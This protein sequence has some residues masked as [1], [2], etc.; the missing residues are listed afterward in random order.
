MN[1]KSLA[2]FAMVLVL[3]FFACD[4][5]SSASSED[6]GT[7]SSSSSAT[8]SS[9]ASKISSSSSSKI[10]SSSSLEKR[11]Y[12]CQKYKCI[13]T[14]Y[15]NQDLL[16][17]GKY[18]ELL[19]ERDQ[20]V[21]RTIKIG[22]Q[23]WMAQGLNLADPA[24]KS[25]CESSAMDDCN[26]KGRLYTWGAAMDSVN[27]GCGYGSKCSPTLP[28]Q[29]ICPKGWHLPDQED[30][31][32][33]FIAVG[34]KS[35]AG[36]KLKSTVGWKSSGDDYSVDGNGDDAFGFSALP[37]GGYENKT[38]WSQG[39]V[40][41]FWSTTMGVPDSL[42]ACYMTL[43][44]SQN[45]I[46]RKCNKKEY[47][48]SV[49]C[50]KDS[51][52]RP[53]LN[54]SSSSAEASSSSVFEWE[55]PKESF[56][57]S[58]IEYESITDDRDGQVY[59]IIKIGELWWMAEN[60]NF[61]TDSEDT[62]VKLRRSWCYDNV[63]DNCNVAGR[64]YTWGGAIDSVNTGCGFGSVCSPTQ[65]VRGVCPKGWHL[66]SREEWDALLF[67][68]GGDDDAGQILK[69]HTG[70]SRENG[71]DTFG[72]S[73]MPAG[74]GEYTM[75]NG[76]YVYEA[77]VFGAA[78]NSAEFW[79]SSEK[80]EYVVWDVIFVTTNEQTFSFGANKRDALSIRCVQDY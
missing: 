74:R 60:L 9:S 67:I 45:G 76:R 25:W 2:L 4:D 35:I 34:G 69:S 30:W 17:A 32:E 66:P 26:V 15:L 22:E 58:K 21:Y 27:T 7:E 41:F 78:K 19:D 42:Q 68:A 73:V 31:E 44:K 33:L 65:P 75:G 50:L 53:S 40:A 20:R 57:N 43:S 14:E 29:G 38:F 46:E 51:P 11:A 28:V 52:N 3:A 12:D 47:G 79:S 16:K 61:D 10:S 18:G 63:A 59:K 80:D 55:Y 36:K 64:L 23:T 1:N 39:E 62:P 37:T 24:H 49:R 72:F 8:S 71:D 77:M 5:S 6:S 70:W 13:T 54:E 56:F 48:Y